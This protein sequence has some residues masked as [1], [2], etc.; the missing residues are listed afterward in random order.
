[1]EI[2]TFGSS[3]SINLVS[4]PLNLHRLGSTGASQVFSDSRS[5]SLQ[6]RSMVLR[7]AMKN[8]KLSDVLGS[9]P[10]F[11]SILLRFMLYLTLSTIYREYTASVIRHVEPRNSRGCQLLLGA[12][13]F[14][15]VPVSRVCF[16]HLLVPYK[17]NL[18]KKTL[19][20]LTVIQFKHSMIRTNHQV[21]HQILRLKKLC[22]Q[23]TDGKV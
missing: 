21:N 1:M 18:S 5:S 6:Y 19:M 23:A 15:V 22:N 3:D 7:L 16:F 9:T 12:S 4:S 17:G 14:S 2:F 10:S 13:L 11:C 20:V 8:W